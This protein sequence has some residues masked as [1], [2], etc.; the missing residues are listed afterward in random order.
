ML[1]MRALSLAS[2]IMLCLS[3]CDK[4]PL[5]G[6]ATSATQP[7]DGL[8]D[9][10]LAK[11]LPQFAK[12]VNEVQIADS[13]NDVDP[14]WVIGALVELNTGKIYSL[15]SYLKATAKPTS[16]PQTDVVF[17]SFVDN[18]VTANAQW[19]EF[20]KAEVNDTTR[21]EVSVT[22]TM[23]VSVDSQSIDKEALLRQLRNNKIASPKDY[24]VVVGYVNYSLIA[25]YFKNTGASGSVSG[26][27]AKIGGSWYSKS[28]HSRV[29]HRI[30][31]VW[32]PLPFVVETITKRVPGNLEDIT[33]DALKKNRIA[34]QPLSI[35]GGAMARIEQS[36]G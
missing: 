21:A 25:T 24:G 5:P 30:V 8:P 2:A 13:F 12:E 26:Y 3:A 33:T 23:K 32:S 1:I 15:D 17:R 11:T 19:L 16:S 9:V 7:G 18:A 27:G 31:A 35:P 6:P 36:K 29:Q 10:S 22:K 28:E 34:V 14:S 20:V 4:K